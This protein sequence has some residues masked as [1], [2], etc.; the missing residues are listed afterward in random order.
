MQKERMIVKFFKLQEVAKRDI[1]LCVLAASI[2]IVVAFLPKRPSSTP[3]FGWIKQWEQFQ[4]AIFSWPFN[5]VVL[6]VL[7]VV[8]IWR[9]FR[10]GAIG[11]AFGVGLA[12]GK[13][14]LHLFLE[15]I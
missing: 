1:V 11:L 8:I 3:P 6:M 9:R 14:T 10:R 4:V 15:A 7:V 12:L 5:I 13:I 2:G